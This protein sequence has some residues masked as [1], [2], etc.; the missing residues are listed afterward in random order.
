MATPFRLP[1]AANPVHRRPNARDLGPRC[2]PRAI[3]ALVY[4]SHIRP[5]AP[6]PPAHCPMFQKLLPK[7]PSLAAP[8]TALTLD[9][10]VNQSAVP[11]GAGELGAAVLGVAGK[12]TAPQE[13][14]DALVHY[15]KFASTAY[16]II[17]PGPSLIPVRPNGQKM[18]GKMFDLLTDSHGYVARDD[19]RAEII[20]AF[21]GSVSPQNFITDALGA[22]VDWDS[23]ISNIQAP[24]GTKIHW[25]FQKAWATLAAKTLAL[26]TAELAAHPTYTLVTAGHS[27]GGAL[28][29]L[30]AVTLQK[31]FQNV[32]LRCYTYGQPRTGNAVWAAWV[33]EVV[34]P[35]RLFRVVHS[36]DGVPTMA[37]AS[38]GFV[39]HSTE[40][41][42]L[43][44][45]SPQQTYI[46][47]APGVAED[48]AGSRKLPTTGINPA[49]LVAGVE[50]ATRTRLESN[51]RGPADDFRELKR[52]PERTGA[53]RFQTEAER[54]P[55]AP[56][57]RI[58][59]PNWL[60]SRP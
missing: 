57:G 39:H 26:V 53:G 28:A 9:Q 55:N 21:R 8:S 45:H 36:N 38:L 17:L 11:Q 52:V 34:T 4:I 49:H 22:L 42:A 1:D 44:P 41:W 27:L 14:Y 19:K 12:P 7:L 37:L 40:Y 13:L 29:A 20:V 6:C 33:D 46:C 16:A 59:R 35:D 10:L 47:V 51:A 50:R 3:R 31:T 24:E 15:F 58:P 56:M 32:P 18:V 60:G 30:A 48:P 43:S 23:T 25:G 2:I 5:I 54:A